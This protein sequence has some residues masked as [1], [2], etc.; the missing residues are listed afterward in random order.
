MSFLLNGHD[1]YANLHEL[2]FLISGNSREFADKNL[3]TFK[4]GV[5]FSVAKKVFADYF[6]ISRYKRISRI[7]GDIK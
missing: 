7:T 4:C 3:T 6:T 1:V 5:T 2:V